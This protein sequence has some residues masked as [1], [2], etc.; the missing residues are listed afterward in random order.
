MREIRM[1]DKKIL[2]LAYLYPP[3]GG[4]GLPGVQRTVKFVRHLSCPKKYVL[5]LRDD[6][7]P[8]FFSTDNRLPLPV[9]G[10][11]IVRTGVTD[12]FRVFLKIR[13]GLRRLTG[14]KS[15]VQAYPHT[16]GHLKAEP[17]DSAKKSIPGRL[18]DIISE[19]LT[20]PDYAYNWIVPTLY[21]GQRLIRQNNIDVIFATGMPWTSMVIGWLLKRL[22]GAKLISD[23]RDPWANNPFLT[24][25]SA[26]MKSLDAYMEQKIVTTADIVSLNT[27]ELRKDFVSRYPDLPEDK[28]VTL[29]NGYD[30]NDFKGVELG[31]SQ[32]EKGKLL[33]SHA[34]FLYGLRDPKPIFEA[35]GKLREKHAEIAGKI[36]LRQMGYTRLNYDLNRFLTENSLNM[37]YEDTGP[38]PFTRCLQNMAGS[39]I[40]VIIQ[41]DTKTQ[42][43]SKIYEYIYL[44]KPILTIASKEG[45]LGK[46]I[47]TYQFGVIFEPD[48]IGGLADYLFQKASDKEKYDRLEAKYEHGYQFDVENITKQLEQIINKIC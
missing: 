21:Q 23:F 1:V 44:N 18:K 28:F 5:T 29:V 15:S 20:F 33:L 24:D 16:R 35:I 12:I 31:E 2:F 30:A 42:I 17:S 11:V 48:D 26:L 36:R 32:T 47:K 38:L 9:N 43:P 7:Y 19:I 4:K 25:K 27:E 6:L 8:D 22:T 34:G 41:Q 40:L 13:E 39:D 46:M 45:A 3:A 37:N 14:G 10:E